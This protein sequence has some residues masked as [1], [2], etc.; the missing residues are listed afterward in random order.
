[1]KCCSVARAGACRPPMDWQADRQITLRAR[2]RAQGVYCACAIG[3]WDRG[4]CCMGWREEVYVARQGLGTM[5][6]RARAGWE[7]NVC[8]YTGDTCACTDTRMGVC[9]KKKRKK[10]AMQC[11]AMRHPRARARCMN[12]GRDRPNP[13]PLYRGLKSTFQKARR[14][15][16]CAALRCAAS[17]LGDD[18]ARFEQV[19]ISIARLTRLIDT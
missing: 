12:N 3:R 18:G 5:R 9:R 13:R 11:D 6:A 2:E 8:M 17:H 4:V 15:C 14:S 10:K 19:V 16:V 1:M 7:V